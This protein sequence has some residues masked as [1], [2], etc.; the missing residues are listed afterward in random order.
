MTTEL[1]AFVTRT[2]VMEDMVTW[3][4]ARSE[5]SSGEWSRRSGADQ[6]GC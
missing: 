2:I 5:L 3:K 6:E 1:G 4:V